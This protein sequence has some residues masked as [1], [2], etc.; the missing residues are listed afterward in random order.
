MCPPVQ[1]LCTN[2]I[3]KNK[4]KLVLQFLIGRRRAYPLEGAEI[5]IC[6]TDQ[7]SSVSIEATHSVSKIP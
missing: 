4:T 6:K 2:K 1:L 5:K 3:I 7:S